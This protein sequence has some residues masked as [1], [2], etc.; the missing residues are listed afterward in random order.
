MT[1]YYDEGYEACSCFW[2]TTP[3]SFVQKAVNKI[4]SLN[5]LNV[6]DAGC[7]EGKN[8]VYL[9]QLGANVLAIDISKSALKNISA[10]WLAIPKIEWRTADI[11]EYELHARTFD[12]I[13]M[14]G[15]LH[16]FQ[17]Q[18]EISKTIERLRGVTNTGGYH[19][20]CAFND[21]EQDLSAH[22]GFKPTLLSHKR[23]LKFYESWNILENTDSDLWEVHPH[24]KIKHM[25]SMTRIIAKKDY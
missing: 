11:R 7:G 24:N 22:P 19:V 15:L 18:E 1:S 14:Y 20:I 16:C 2:G 4:E 17:S 23:Y 12:L 21:R 9:A 8:A 3:G 10:E 13:I 25:H 5:E 6:L